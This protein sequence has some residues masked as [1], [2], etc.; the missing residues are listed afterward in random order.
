[1]EAR[2]RWLKRVPFCGGRRTSGVSPGEV[3]GVGKLERASRNGGILPSSCPVVAPGVID[4]MPTIMIGTIRPF[5]VLVTVV[6][7]VSR[8]APRGFL[9]YFFC[10]QWKFQT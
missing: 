5:A 1:M 7:S 4:L 8:T 9:V 6:S 3:G 2:R 10:C